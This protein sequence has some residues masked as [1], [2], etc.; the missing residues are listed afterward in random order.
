M[1]IFLGWGARHTVAVLGFMAF[2][3]SYAM[4]FN[5]SLA[6]VAMVKP[7]NSNGHGLANSSISSTVHEVTCSHLIEESSEDSSPTASQ[8][9]FEWNEAEQGFILGSFFWG[10]VLT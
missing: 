5:L 8:G 1:L 9:E 3:I 6:I 4:R 10:Y 2:G 7:R